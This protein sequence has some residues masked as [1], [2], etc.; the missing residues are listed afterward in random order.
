MDQKIESKW[1]YETRIDNLSLYQ[2][3]QI[4]KGTCAL[5]MGTTRAWKWAKTVHATKITRKHH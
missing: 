5:K 1:A 3:A 4:A 2:K